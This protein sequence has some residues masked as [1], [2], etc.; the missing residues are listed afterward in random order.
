MKAGLDHRIP[1]SP[2]A[3]EILHAMER[4]RLKDNKYVFVGLRPGRPVHHMAMWELLKGMGFNEIT[5]HGFRSTFSDW[6]SEQTVFLM[7]RGNRPWRI[8]SVTRQ[9]RHIAA[10]TN[11]RSAGS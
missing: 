5:V 10:A 11:S 8:K 7:R 2:R 1:L 3:L 9:T 4:L 6:V